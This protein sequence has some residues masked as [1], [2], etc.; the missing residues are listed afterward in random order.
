MND[1]TFAYFALRNKRF[2]TIILEMY[3]IIFFSNRFEYSLRII[4]IQFLR[5][6]YSRLKP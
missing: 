5:D 1:E 2:W 3:D 6:R 4:I